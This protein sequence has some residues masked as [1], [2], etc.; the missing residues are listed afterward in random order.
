MRI[1][2]AGS[3]TDR[4][5]PRRAAARVM[6][7]RRGLDGGPQ[8]VRPQVEEHETRVELRE[9]E[10]VLSEPV[11]ALDLAGAGLQELRPRLGIVAGGLHEELVERA[12]GGQR[13]PQ[14]VRHVGEEVAA[15]V[16]VAAADLDALLEP[17]GHR[18][19]LDGEL[20]ELR[21]TGPQLGRRHAPRQVA[22]GEGRARRR[23]AGATGS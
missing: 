20:A 2:D 10:Q 3:S 7:V 21:G 6:L 16:A 19:E 9:L 1:G 11:E 13:G 12:Q 17:V 23:S 15:A 8:V 18:V 5:T 22:L 14:L 4:R